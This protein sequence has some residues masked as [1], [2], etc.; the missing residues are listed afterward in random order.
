MKRR[1][2]RLAIV[3]IALTLLSAPILSLDHGTAQENADS[4]TFV[5]LYFLR[6]DEI[7]VAV[8]ERSRLVQDTS[9]Y[10]A[11]LLELLRGPAD[12]ELGAGL[13]TTIP[14]GVSILNS[15]VVVNGVATVDLSREFQA[16]PNEGQ[17][18]SASL[19]ARRM[20][21]VVFT[22]TQFD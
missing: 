13:V 11:T 6:D 21:Q 20:G 15:V 4:E 1:L 19:L 2:I 22:L 3:A 8:R 9:I 12:D 14:S 17:T 5:R 18:A 7:G 16:G 10:F